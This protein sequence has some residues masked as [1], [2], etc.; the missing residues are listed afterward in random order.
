MAKVLFVAYFIMF[1]LLFCIGNFIG[2][3]FL[4][5]SVTAFFCS[6]FIALASFKSYERNVL[7]KLSDEEFVKSIKQSEE[8]DDLDEEIS[9][10]SEK[11]R[12]KREGLLSG[13]KNINIGTALFPYRLV[14]YAL[15]FISFLVL[16][17]H[18]ILSIGGFL[19]GVSAMPVG[20]LIFAVAKGFYGKH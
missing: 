8:D 10:K 5:S 14:A 19:T 6:V 11:E 15:L 12:L 17:R 13:L 3:K 20:T 9:I 7:V 1:I 18:E 16:L 4:I 2:I